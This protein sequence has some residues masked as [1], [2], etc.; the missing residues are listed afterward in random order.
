MDTYEQR[1][2][3]LYA[4]IVYTAVAGIFS[5]LLFS[6]I[7]ITASLTCMVSG[8]YSFSQILYTIGFPGVAIAL[9]LGIV[10]IVSLVRLIIQY[11]VFSNM[12][13]EVM[14]GSYAI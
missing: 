5:A 1:L 8:C 14:K 10:A 2:D 4:D 3:N 13:N 11:H 6:I 7:F 9:A 12:I